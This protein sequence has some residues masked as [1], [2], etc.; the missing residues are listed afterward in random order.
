MP[1]AVGSSDNIS[2][3]AI[4]LK[5]QRVDF[6]R[7]AHAALGNPSWIAQH[8]LP[9]GRRLGQCWVALNPNRADKHLGSF[10]VNL[11]NGKWA[12][13]AIQ[14][15]AGMDLISLAAYVLRISQRE[16]A[17]YVAQMLNIEPWEV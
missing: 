6:H 8:I 2:Q 11:T 7:I 16:A 14:N 4:G 9:Q 12:D 10:K 17:L 13:F 3:N 1:S 15:A 5:F